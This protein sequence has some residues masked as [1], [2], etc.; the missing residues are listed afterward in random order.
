VRAASAVQLAAA[1][2]VVV[3]TSPP[4]ITGSGECSSCTGDD[5]SAFW[6]TH[7]RFYAAWGSWRTGS[8]QTY[9]GGFSFR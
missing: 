3:F 5:T 7:D 6:L 4:P 1:H 8:L 2:G 9:W